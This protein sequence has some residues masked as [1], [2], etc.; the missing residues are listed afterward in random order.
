MLKTSTTF[1]SQTSCSQ[2]PG[3]FASSG[4][5]PQPIAFLTQV[6]IFLLPPPLTPLLILLP[7]VSYKH[8]HARTLDQCHRRS[9][10]LSSQCLEA[11]PVDSSPHDHASVITASFGCRV[12]EEILSFTQFACGWRGL[13][14]EANEG[15]DG[16]EVEATV[17]ALRPST[18]TPLRINWLRETKYGTHAMLP[19]LLLL[20]LLLLIYS[21]ELFVLVRE[22][23]RRGRG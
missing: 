11:N 17:Q 3:T 23:R 9:T 10:T 6:C 21:R 15:G 4:P 12:G 8:T 1:A 18:A 5:L 22:E 16:E 2:L 13:A 20:L 7:S 14:R 19:Q